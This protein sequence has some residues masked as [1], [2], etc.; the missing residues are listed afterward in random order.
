MSS[1]NS[2]ECHRDS[3]NA[4]DCI[5]LSFRGVPL[6]AAGPTSNGASEEQT[7]TT[8]PSGRERG[9]RERGRR[10]QARERETRADLTNSEAGQTAGYKTVD[11]RR[12]RHQS[13]LTSVS[14]STRPANMKVSATFSSSFLFPFRPTLGTDESSR[15]ASFGRLFPSPVPVRSLCSLDSGSIED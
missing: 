12:S 11:R 2:R 4:G 9:A 13:R 8:V 7:E 6:P 1:V 15:V 10:R 14:C 5:Y 3:R